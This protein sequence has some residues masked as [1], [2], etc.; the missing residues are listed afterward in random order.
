M[1][2]QSRGYQEQAGG[3]RSQQDARE[4]PS[5]GEI[6]PIQVPFDAHPV[7]EGLKRQVN[8]LICL[9][10]N[11]CEPPVAIHRQQ[12]DHAA[13]AAGELGNL[14]VDRGG[15]EGGIDSLEISARM[16]DSSK[17]SVSPTCLGR[18]PSRGCR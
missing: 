13:V 5:A 8:V 16:R 9:D 4:I 17:A 1:V 6:S 15:P 14:A 2:L 7:I 3:L 11:D 18:L 10:F 12:V